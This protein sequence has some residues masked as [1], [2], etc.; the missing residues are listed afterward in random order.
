MVSSPDSRA[1]RSVYGHASLVASPFTETIEFYGCLAR[2]LGQYRQ[3]V[4]L[5]IS[6]HGLEL[7]VRII[8]RS[9]PSV[10]VRGCM[11]ALAFP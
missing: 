6:A 8:E 7:H 5:V 2:E 4:F 9:P 3:V 11:A 10:L 1:P